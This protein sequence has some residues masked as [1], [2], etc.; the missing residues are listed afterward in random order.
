M[1]NW[2]G[3]SQQAFSTFSPDL[4]NSPPATVLILVMGTCNP[5]IHSVSLL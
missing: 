1:K 2:V 3:M 5:Q 4:A